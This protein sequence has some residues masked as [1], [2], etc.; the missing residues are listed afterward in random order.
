MSLYWKCVFFLL[1]QRGPYLLEKH[2]T[3]VV[4]FPLDLEYIYYF[5]KSTWDNPVIHV[6]DSCISNYGTRNRGCRGGPPPLAYIAKAF[7]YLL[8]ELQNSWTP[9]K[10]EIMISFWILTWLLKLCMYN[11][12]NIYIYISTRKKRDSSVRPPNVKNMFFLEVLYGCF[13]RNPKRL[14]IVGRWKHHQWSWRI[15]GYPIY[16]WLIRIC[17]CM[18][19]GRVNLFNMI[20]CFFFT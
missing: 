3:V 9:I 14:S 13:S 6:L 1:F 11:I 16:I 12:L 2:W 5:A 19:G 10:R 8:A 4:Y 15:Q 20:P 7:R 18:I 17:P